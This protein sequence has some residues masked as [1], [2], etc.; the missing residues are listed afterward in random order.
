MATNI[1]DSIVSMFSLFLHILLLEGIESFEGKVKN[2]IAE[3][4]ERCMT[5]GMLTQS[6][7]LF[8]CNQEP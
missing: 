4:K 1:T 8:C 3:L 6:H 2:R 5:P 7:T